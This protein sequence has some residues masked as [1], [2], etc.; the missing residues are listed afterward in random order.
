M[1]PDSHRIPVT[2]A[3]LP[4]AYIGAF[5]PGVGNPAS[6]G[7][8]SGDKNVPQGFVN[9]PPV[10]WGPRVGF[11]YDVFGNGKTA[12]RGGAAILYNPRLSKVG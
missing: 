12:L 6:G 5:V 11:A 10:L 2:G 7:A 4:A 8:T 9:Q 3:L 1:G